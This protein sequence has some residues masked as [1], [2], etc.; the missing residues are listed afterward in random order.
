MQYTGMIVTKR[1]QNSKVK[2]Q[3]T[4]AVV[5]F[6]LLNFAF[7]LYHLIFSAASFASVNVLSKEYAFS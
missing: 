1:M 5:D 2:T 4:F 6:L 3:N 7:L